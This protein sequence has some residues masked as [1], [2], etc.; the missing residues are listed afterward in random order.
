MLKNGSARFIQAT[1]RFSVLP[2]DGFDKGILFQ[3]IRSLRDLTPDSVRDI[4]RASLR[5]PS[6]TLTTMGPLQD[7]SGTNDAFNSSICSLEVKKGSNRTGS[8]HT[9]T[10]TNTHTNTHTQH[11]H[12]A[13]SSLTNHP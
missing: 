3:D 13:Q 4:L 6:L 8:D 2:T 5:D 9:H 1:Y 12:H 11:H 7:M 10:H